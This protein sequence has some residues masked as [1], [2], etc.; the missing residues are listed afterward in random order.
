MRALGVIAASAVLVACGGAPRAVVPRAVSSSGDE[1]VAAIGDASLS[2][3]ARPSDGRTWMSLWIDAGSRDVDPAGIATVAAWAIAEGRGIE[4]R[5]IPDGTELHVGCESAQVEACVEALA[6]ALGARSIEERALDAALERLR[7]TRRGARADVARAADRLAIAALTGDAAG[8]DPLGEASADASITRAEVERF[9]ATHYGPA[10]ALF[11][12][13]G[14]ADEAR[15]RAAIADALVRAPAA[16]GVRAA[17]AFVPSV[18]ARVDVDEQSATSVAL[19]VSDVPR[20]L[21]IARRATAELEGGSASVFPLRGGEIVLLRGRD[22]DEVIAAATYARALG[23]ERVDALAEDDPR[24]LARRVGAR[25]V[26]RTSER[27]EGGLGVG[28]VIAG[29]RGDANADDPD[30]R[31]R[32]EERTRIEALARASDAAARGEGLT[33]EAD[34]EGTSIRDEH[35]TRVV[36]RA[37]PIGRV[38]IAVSIAGGVRDEPARVQGRSALLARLLA[39]CVDAHDAE[40]WVDASS[41]GASV[42]VAPVRALDAVESITR[43]V[44]RLAWSPASLEE[45]R[46]RAIASLDG[47][48]ERLARAA[49]VLVPGAPGMIAPS[50]T[51]ASLAA[52]DPRSIERAWARLATRGAVTVAIVGEV[53]ATS[54][55]RAAMLGLVSLPAPESTRASDAIASVGSEEIVAVR[56]VDERVE[57]T[58]ALRDLAPRASDDVGARAALDAWIAALDGPALRVVWARSGSGA[59][60]AWLA[61]AV[62]GDEETIAA[63]PARI[64]RARDAARARIDE[65]L[66]SAIGAMREVRARDVAT[67]RARARRLARA[68][69]DRAID[70]SASSRTARALIDGAPRYVIARP[71]AA[72]E[73]RGR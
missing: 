34:A 4:A 49:S 67:A 12:V 72:E 33:E 48:S 55:A 25:W 18:G 54:I 28:A 23:G 8:M 45:V 27:A 62:R 36:V 20:A 19:A 66:A 2:V 53:D 13:I 14:D 3:I 16:S 44:R 38:A 35:G 32:D 56:S 63:L 68:D 65:A 1:Q 41:F 24:S 29:G 71:P 9:V 15:V 61:I 59:E 11:V 31:I 7:A 64:D 30:A 42:E 37:A 46:A 22:A 6:G 69:E 40:A 57:V 47:D 5:V 51:L 60:G 43:C 21:A 70:E 58:I 39:R 10:R 73:Q 26:A 50:G 52:I 17:R